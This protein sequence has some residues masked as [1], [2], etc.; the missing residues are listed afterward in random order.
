MKKIGINKF[1]FYFLFCV[2][3]FLVIF[4]EYLIFV[5]FIFYIGIIAPIFD[6][7]IMWKITYKKSSEKLNIIKDLNLKEAFLLHI[8]L[9]I[10]FILGGAIGFIISVWLS[11][12]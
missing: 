6:Y 11:Q 4:K 1:E 12:P 10:S 7:I 8:P 5:F 9:L 2:G 3:L